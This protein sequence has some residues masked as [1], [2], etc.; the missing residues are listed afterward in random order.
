[1]S[2]PMPLPDT[3]LKGPDQHIPYQGLIYPRPLD[4]RLLD[5]LPDYDNDIDDKNQPEVSIRQP[6]KT[7][8]R[9]PRKLLG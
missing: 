5:T 2:R 7:M 9:K 1:M 4:I 6:N 3:I 8:Y